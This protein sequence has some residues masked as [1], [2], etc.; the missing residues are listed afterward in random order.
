MYKWNMKHEAQDRK[1]SDMQCTCHNKYA[2]LSLFRL[3]LLLQKHCFTKG[4]SGWLL[5][6][7]STQC[8]CLKR[9]IRLTVEML[10][11]HTCNRLL[12][13]HK[14][15]DSFVSYIRDM[16]HVCHIR[17]MTHAATHATDDYDYNGF[18]YV[19]DPDENVLT[20]VWKQYLLSFYWYTFTCVQIWCDAYM[21]FSEICICV[22][23]CV[24]THEFLRIYI[25]YIHDA[26]V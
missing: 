14:R 24:Y 12:R 23:V 18:G 3:R 5:R 19:D 16:T 11:Q 6:E 4:Q 2:I 21:N 7:C 25:W 15:H 1:I 13:L 8:L 9:E 10:L 26:R 20:R 17:D 22:C